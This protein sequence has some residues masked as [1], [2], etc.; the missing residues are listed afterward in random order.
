MP[1]PCKWCCQNPQLGSG[2]VPSFCT[3]CQPVMPRDEGA[4]KFCAEL[5]LLRGAVILTLPPGTKDRHTGE[6]LYMS[7]IDD[8]RKIV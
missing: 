1:K 5:A 4:A 6:D 8:L 7:A 2:R 3:D